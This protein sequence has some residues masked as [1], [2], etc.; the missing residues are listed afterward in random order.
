MPP[1]LEDQVVASAVPVEVETGS[2]EEVGA[3]AKGERLREGV[4]G[5]DDLD[6]TAER[7]TVDARRSGCRKSFESWPRYRAC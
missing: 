1:P 5:R 7:P 6:L 4:V 3:V 2:A